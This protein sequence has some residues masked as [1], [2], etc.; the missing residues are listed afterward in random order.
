MTQ[1]YIWIIRG[2]NLANAR[3]CYNVTPPLI[4]WV[5]TRNNSW[6]DMVM[7]EFKTDISILTGRYF[8]LATGVGHENMI[9]TVYVKPN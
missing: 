5:S 9:Y 3:R 2:I 7:V 8:T 1:G 4:G 6:Y